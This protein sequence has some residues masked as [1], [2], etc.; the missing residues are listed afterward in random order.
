MDDPLM[1]ADFDPVSYINRS[2][3][4]ESSLQDLDTFV[5]SI[6]SQIS[7][8]EKEI[9]STVQV[10][11]LN[12]HQT[13]SDI[14]QA[15]AQIQDLSLKMGSIKNK[16][17]DS[18]QMVEDICADIKK[19]DLAKTHLQTSIT[20]LKRLQML[21]TALSQLETLTSD[22]RSR[23]TA[24]MLD[25]VEQL[26]SNFD[27]YSNVPIVS[28]I[29]E[30]IKLIRSYLVNQVKHAFAEVGY[31]ADAAGGLGGSA[32]ANMNE[33]PQF[34]RAKL[35]DTCILLDS[36]GYT[37]RRDILEDFVRIQLEP[38]EKLFGES[39]PHFK[40]DQVERRW[41]WFK[42][43]LKTIDDSYTSIFPT[44]WR[45]ALRVCL[46]FTEKTK[47]H[48]VTLLNKLDSTDDIDVHDLLKALKT[49]IRFEQDMTNRFDL[50]EIMDTFAGNK[51]EG[52]EGGEDSLAAAQQE[53]ANDMKL[54]DE[55]KV[56]Y[57]VTDHSTAERLE[58]EE[59]G[60]LK[61]ACVAIVGDKGIAGVFDKFLGCYVELER[62]NLEEMITKL[63]EED[64]QV[65]QLPSGGLSEYEMG[66][67]DDDVDDDDE[68]VEK[69]ESTASKTNACVYGS[70]QNIFT[71]IK[72]S[73]KRCTV[74][75]T[76][77]TF[78]SLC[79]EIKHCLQQYVSLLKKRCPQEKDAPSYFPTD[80]SFQKTY[81]LPMDAEI[82][83][84]YLI[85]T[86]EYC[87]DLVPQLE[88]MAKGKISPEFEDRIDF[89]SESDAFMDV[90]A[91][92]LKILTTGLLERLRPAFTLMA[93]TSWSNVNQVDQESA[94]VRQFLNVL[95]DAFPKVRFSL[96]NNYFQTLCT[97]V[98]SKALEIYLDIINK[99]KLISELGSQQL[100][101]DLY[102][103]K[104]AIM[105]LHSL[106]EEEKSNRKPPAMYEKMVTSRLHHIETMLKLINTPEEENI[107]VERFRTLWP[108]G[109]REDL[110]RILNLKGI[111]KREQK[112][113]MELFELNSQA[114]F[115]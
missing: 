39:A 87:S 58:E 68:D 29:R 21:V 23:E 56:M 102:H 31:L 86:G 103:M 61:A 51:A 54:R 93:T 24:N 99:Q 4:D 57:V 78:V 46:E 2:F 76:R 81:Q 44:H 8:I 89:N 113:I 74:F 45:M 98:A 9:S 22:N 91:L 1:K 49:A 5:L 52:A 77:T 16:A 94:Y 95:N 7:I 35:T 100:L 6:S 47:I 114:N 11:S 66:M 36:L 83:I 104:P 17:S 109:S 42:R 110:E 60:F 27:S 71:F 18:E 107:L 25:A 101:L 48:L 26:M 85:N 79:Q 112:N 30:R 13:T 105:N 72:N 96:N 70:S 90:V 75:S 50:R 84:C 62:Q 15:L 19:L 67:D 3:P 41:A 32:N 14:S 63:H 80:T 55:N 73:I 37:A 88:E 115:N 59:S 82:L 64:D 111:K 92:A 53:I 28:D 20:S 38:Y 108:D 10:Q 43:L 106:G 33:D 40:L 34:F 12:R 65:Q 97:K 69:L